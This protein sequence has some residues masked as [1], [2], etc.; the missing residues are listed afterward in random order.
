MNKGWKDAIAVQKDEIYM[1]I[2]DW[3]CFI[4]IKLNGMYFINM[5]KQYQDKKLHFTL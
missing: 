3:N 5:W 4:K 2:F 1:Y